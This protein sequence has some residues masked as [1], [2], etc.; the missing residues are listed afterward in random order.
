M[1]HTLT[2]Q[3]LAVFVCL[4]W[5]VC[6]A[7]AQLL[8]TKAKQA[9]M[10]DAVTGTVLFEK[11][12]DSPVPPAS[13]AKLMTMEVVF[14]ALKTGR[15][16]IA[17]TFPVSENAWRTGGAPSGTSTMFAALKSQIALPDL[18]RGVIVQSANDACIIIAEGLAGNEQEFAV[19]MN[20]RAKIIGLT[21]SEFKNATGLPAAGQHVSMRDLVKL[22]THIWREYPDYYGIY[23]EPEFTWNK[24]T[25][26]NRNPLLA[27]NVGADGM[28]TGFTEESGYAIL[29]SA[30]KGN[31]RLFMAM[32]GLATDR[33]RA[34]EARKMLEWAQSSFSRQVLFKPLESMGEATV[35]GGRG[36]SV[37]VGSEG[38]VSVLIANENR[39]RL[40]A[41]VVYNGPIIAPIAKGQEIGVL[42]VYSGD[43]LIQVTPVVALSN[44]TVG[45]L[46]ERA[47]SSAK[48][49]ATGWIRG[50]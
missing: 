46:S 37:P 28:S 32:S 21:G 16:T 29:G 47:L 4:F 43:V 15:R 39:V 9:F 10:I 13:L 27:L 42:N 38:E 8:D 25:Q 33:E 22:G 26:R 6:A 34:E 30:E 5:S 11:D 20:Q 1:Q 44:V 35:F 31:M 24:I 49:L 50:L 45:S 3:F 41:N 14:H 48:E 36:L 23:A 17:E 7:Q 40:R 2:Q 19:A 12:A 18:I